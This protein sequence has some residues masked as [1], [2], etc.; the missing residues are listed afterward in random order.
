VP[1]A[2]FGYMASGIDDEV[3][4]RAKPRGFLK[5]Q[6]YPR[7]LNDVSKVDTGVELFGAK[8][9]SPILVQGAWRCRALFK[10]FKMFKTK[11]LL[12]LLN[13]LNILNIPRAPRA[14]LPNRITGPIPRKDALQPFK[15]MPECLRYGWIIW[16]DLTRRTAR[17]GFLPSLR[18]RA[19]GAHLIPS[20][21]HQLSSI[22]Q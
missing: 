13:I 22:A 15:T 1:P 11:A 2:H 17:Q 20:C 14:L 18:G 10:T 8:Y 7:R 5:F 16:Q 9:D 19:H 3:T 12:R 21:R 6:L 4:L